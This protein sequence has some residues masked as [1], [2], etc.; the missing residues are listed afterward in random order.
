MIVKRRKQ[1]GSLMINLTQD[2]RDRFEV[3][4]EQEA[5]SNAEV[6]KQLDKLPGGSY[7][8]ELKKTLRGEALAM[9]VV[10]K[11]LRDTETQTTG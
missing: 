6:I 1:W 2:E 9:R 8:D 10:A 4:L 11:R 7:H 3:Y 5:A